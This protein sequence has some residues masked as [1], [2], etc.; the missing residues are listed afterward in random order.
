MHPKKAA[1]PLPYAICGFFYVLQLL[2]MGLY[3]LKQNLS[4]VIFCF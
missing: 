3:H 2:K 1:I 4:T